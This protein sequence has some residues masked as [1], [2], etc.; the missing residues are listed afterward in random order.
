MRHPVPGFA[1]SGLRPTSDLN[2]TPLIDVLLVLL[3][4]FLVSLPLS[5]RGLDSDIPPATHATSPEVPTGQIVVDIAADRSIR[6]NQQPIRVADLGPRLRDIYA[7]RRDKT[8]FVIGDGSLP[9]GDVIAVIDA[10]RG[11]GIERVGIIT[12]GMRKAART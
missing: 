8:I 7:A 10:A 12:E 6:I 9:Y 5:Q 2:I 3:V 1:P 4:L 11:A